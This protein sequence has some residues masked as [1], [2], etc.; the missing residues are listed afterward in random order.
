[1]SQIARFDFMR[2][3]RQE[4]AEEFLGFFLNTLGEETVGLLAKQPVEVREAVLGREAVEGSSSSTMT[5]ESTSANEGSPNA[6]GSSGWVEVGKK[7]KGSLLRQSGAGEST[8][9]ALTRLFTG[10]YRS[11]L[12]IP[13]HPSIKPSISIEP[14]SP[15]Q[16]HIQPSTVFSVET[17]LQHLPD[18]ET[19]NDVVLPS[20]TSLKGSADA[21]RRT[22]LETLPKVL[23]LHLKRFGWAEGAR[24]MGK[25][26]AFGEE[27]VVPKEAIAPSRRTARG[28]RYKL[29]GGAF[30]HP[31]TSL[32]LSLSFS[33][34]LVGTMRAD[35]VPFNWVFLNSRLPSRTDRLVRPLHL[36]RPLAL[37]PPAVVFLDGFGGGG[38]PVAAHRRRAS[39]GGR[40]RRR[41]HLRGERSGGRE[42]RDWWEGEMCLPAILREG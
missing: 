21:T 38:R 40:P 28:P 10:S 16:L 15:L 39:D 41:G 23:V 29:F 24:K 19:I 3:G 9:T 25:V 14:F 7:G 17:A 2:Q 12:T 30:F 20:S 5:A 26:V 33:C 32:S 34:F 8:L 36:C 1:M 35:P 13:S 42:W 37:P 18:P 4:D 6:D 22:E 27:L 31:S 11:T